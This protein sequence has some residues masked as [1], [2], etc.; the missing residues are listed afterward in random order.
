MQNGSWQQGGDGQEA[1][2]EL[3]K[4]RAREKLL[5]QVATLDRT[6]SC[7]FHSSCVSSC[8]GMVHSP[9]S[10]IRTSIIYIYNYNNSNISNYLFVFIYVYIKF[11]YCT[12]T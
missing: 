12:G 10:G 7:W 9:Y 1:R 2:K 6:L 3:E 8:R 4:E 5:A 11:C